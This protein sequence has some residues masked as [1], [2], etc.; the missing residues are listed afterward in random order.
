MSEAI[1]KHFSKEELENMTVEDLKELI[2]VMPETVKF[3]ATAAVFDKDGNPK[4]DNPSRRGYF[5]EV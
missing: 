1:K 4:Y 3:E 5:D 2:G